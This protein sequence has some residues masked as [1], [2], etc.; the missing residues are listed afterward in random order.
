MSRKRS[1]L[2]LAVLLAAAPVASWATSPARPSIADCR[3]DKK[4]Y[5]PTASTAAAEAAC[6]QP[7]LA[8]L[9][10]A[11]RAWVNYWDSKPHRAKPS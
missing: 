5:C 7:H 8:Q 4:T 2:I 10:A 3:K 11:C 6:L 9:T 1:T